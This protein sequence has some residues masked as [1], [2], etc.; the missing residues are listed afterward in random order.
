[1]IPRRRFLVG[2]LASVALAAPA[3]FVRAAPVSFST[4]PFTLGVAS[5]CPREDRVI[6]W[7]RLAPQP[8]EGGG[9]RDA[10]VEVEW[11]DCGG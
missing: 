9:M 3:G 1:M 11:P 8:L 2:S 10:S 7:T 4:D 5:G 6:L